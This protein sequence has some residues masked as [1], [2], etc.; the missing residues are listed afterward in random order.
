V[1]APLGERIARHIRAEG[2]LSLALYMALA[3]YDREGGYYARHRPIGA[4]GDFVTAPEISQVFGELLGLWCADLWDRSG[5]PDPVI[6]A[7]LGP[8]RG[9]MM[10]DL[11][12]AAALVPAFR[13]ALR[14]HLVEAS[15]S[16]REEQRARLAAAAPVLVDRVEDLPEGPLIVVANEFLDALPVRQ[17]VRGAAAWAERLVALGPDGG[18]VFAQGPQEP[19]LRHLVPASLREAAPGTIVEICPAALS[20]AAMLGRRFARHWGAALFVDYGYFPST[21]GPTLRALSRH[22]PVPV[23]A[24]PG[25]ADLSADVDFA[26]FAEAARAGG[27]ATYGPVPQGRF[28]RALGAEARLAGLALQATAAQRESL[29]SGLARLLDP[30][31][32]GALFRALALTSPGLPRPDGFAGE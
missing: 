32:M 5:R 10:A 21:P 25:D 9:T 20:L 7:E 8:G 3:L 29:A 13:R 24:T 1:S 4:A 31:A 16:L 15:A 27:A 2:P 18:L 11:L 28:L 14:L 17:L 30:A 22:R 19:A 12:R 26:A 6:L 23:L